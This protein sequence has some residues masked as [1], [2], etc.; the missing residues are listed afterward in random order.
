MLSFE[1]ELM[2]CSQ[3]ETLGLF[4][5]ADG[6]GGHVNGDQAS[7]L[8]VTAFSSFFFEK[9]MPLFLD[10]NSD[11]SSVPERLEEAV[12]E[13]N[14]TILD[15]LP[16]SG[17]T[18]TAA[19]IWGE[20]LYCAHV[21]DSRLLIL[22]EKGSIEK[23]TRDHSLVQ[24]MVELGEITEDEALSHPRR[25]VLLRSLGFESAL[26]VDLYEKQLNPGDVAVLCCDGLWSTVDLEKISRIIHDEPVLQKAADELVNA[27]NKAGGPDNISC[28][29]VKRNA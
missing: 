23:I 26:E 6:M 22:D 25:S 10:Q 15:H 16:G 1:I 24:M 11:L 19:L 13:A 8:A 17:T 4:A 7:A 27:A 28:I 9:I 29:L 14:Q 3:V 21:G 2:R 12:I 20:R 5:I 18:F